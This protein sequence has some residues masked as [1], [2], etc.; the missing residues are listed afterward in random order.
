MIAM[1]VNKLSELRFGHFSKKP[2]GEIFT[3]KKSLVR[4]S[5]TRRIRFLIYALKPVPN[6]RPA[7][8]LAMGIFP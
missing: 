3:L 7:K 2:V 8:D 6:M 4:F 1:Q 5:P